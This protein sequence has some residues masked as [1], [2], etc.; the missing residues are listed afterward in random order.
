MTQLLFGPH[1]FDEMHVACDCAIML[2]MAVIPPVVASFLYCTLVRRSGIGRQWM[3]VS[4]AV[5]AAFGATDSFGVAV[6]YHNSG[7]DHGLLAVGFRT[8]VILAQL[9]VPLAIGWWFLRRKHDQGQLQLA[10]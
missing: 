8:C 7:E 4:C 2:L 10:S 5:L 3:F 1:A 6:M 9:L